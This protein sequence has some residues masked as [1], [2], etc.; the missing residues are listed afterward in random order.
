DLLV[1]STDGIGEAK[2][3]AGEMFGQARLVEVV[4]ANSEK[5]AHEIYDAIVEAV[6]QFQADRAQDDD[7]T[8]V[9]VKCLPAAE[10]MNE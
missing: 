6:G 7:I 9:I 5:S 3:P 10:Q 8:L 4:R 1:M 2:N